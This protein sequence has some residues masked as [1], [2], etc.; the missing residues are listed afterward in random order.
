MTKFEKSLLKDLP[1]C[2]YCDATGIISGGGFLWDLEC[3]KCLGTKKD[4][5]YYHKR[6]EQEQMQEIYVSIDVESDGP[7]P[8]KYSMLSLGAAAFEESGKL[9][10]TFS[11]NLE[12]LPDAIQDPG[13]MEWWAKQKDAWDAHR[14]NTV[15]PEKG[16]RS[17]LDWTSNLKGNPVC[18]AYP[19]GFDFLFTYWYL[20]NFTGTSPFSFSCLDIKTLAMAALKCNYKKASKRNMPKRWFAENVSHTHVAEED[21]I[22]QGFL[23]CNI[24]KEVKS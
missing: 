12:T 6:I 16:M 10:D 19:A 22:E 21:A 8:G 3:P 13:T 18:V 9:I 2:D 14:K 24:W 5:Y 11:V 15:A 17:F 20:I 1:W 23:F 7:I 4:Y